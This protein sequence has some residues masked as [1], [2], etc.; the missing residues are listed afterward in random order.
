MPLFSRWAALEDVLVH[1]RQ[2]L[3]SYGSDEGILKLVPV[4]WRSLADRGNLLATIV[5]EGAEPA[6]RLPI[7]TMAGVFVDDDFADSIER[8]NEKLIGE[9]IAHEVLIH[10]KGILD[11]QGIREHQSGGG[12]NFAVIHGLFFDRNIAPNYFLQAKEMAS[13]TLFRALRGYR[14]RSFYREVSD[15]ASVQWLLRGG[16]KIVERKAGDSE[17]T[18]GTSKPLLL[19]V[20]RSEAE[21]E[22]GTR[23]SALFV[24]YPAYF[25]LKATFRELLNVALKG[26]TDKQIAEALSL[27]VPAVKRRW[28]RLYIHV[29]ACYPAL[30]KSWS[31][32]VVESARGSERRRHL[33]NY[34]RDHPEEL[35][36]W[37]D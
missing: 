3:P 15:P 30:W 33:L 20:T 29:E 28:E 2:L 18:A 8:S 16:M 19:R 7:H 17:T 12:L 27:S 26:S 5:E 10:G 4:V 14:L 34:F 37:V 25:G 31:G 6:N 24:E 1:R 9:L 23:M 22:E 11:L 32:E 35:R 36:P 13:Q 21:S